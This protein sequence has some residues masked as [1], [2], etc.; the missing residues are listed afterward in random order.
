MT[1]DLLLFFVLW[2]VILLLFASSGVLLFGTLP[3]YPDFITVLFMYYESSLGNWDLSIYCTDGNNLSVDCLV[4]KTWMLVFLALNMVLLLNLIIAILS[5]TYGIFEDKKKGLY[6]E[7]LVAKFA[8]LEFD[9]M[10]GAS[11]CAQLPLNA[12]V[13]P[14]WWVTLIPCLSDE[15]LV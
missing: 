3:E 11:A 5:T 15:F 14:F 1:G 4:G 7:V 10:Y 9:E 2:F 8:T 6:Y 12:M 13:F